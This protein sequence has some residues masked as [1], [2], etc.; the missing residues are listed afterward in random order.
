MEFIIPITGAVKFNITL[1]PTVWIF[2][3][4]RIDL[5][6][7]F[8][9]K[10]EYKDADEEY[11]KV[12]SAHWSREIIEGSTNP[13]TLKSE[14]KY[15]KTKMLSNTYGIELKQFILNAEPLNEAKNLVIET[16]EGNHTISLE[17]VDNILVKFSHKGKPL[18]EDG[19]VHIIKKDGSN[20]NDPIRNVTAFR[21]E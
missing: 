7:F 3:D 12:T 10:Y 11:T 1:D 15:E 13:P 16:N 18:R 14:K 19:P 8:E 20:L 21:L 2:D 9:G 5:D 17:E 4:R 6:E